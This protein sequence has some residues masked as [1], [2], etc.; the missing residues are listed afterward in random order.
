MFEYRQTWDLYSN[1]K[2]KLRAFTPKLPWSC[3]PVIGVTLHCWTYIEPASGF[4]EPVTSVVIY[5]SKEDMEDTPVMDLTAQISQES[6]EKDG[7]PYRRIVISDLDLPCFEDGPTCKMLFTFEHACVV[8]RTEIVWTID[9]GGSR[10]PLPDTLPI[11]WPSKNSPVWLVG[12]KEFV[13]KVSRTISD[14]WGGLPSASGFIPPGIHLM[15]VDQIL[16]QSVESN[17]YSSRDHFDG[18]YRIVQA[19][20]LIDDTLC[21]HTAERTAEQILVFRYG[22][23]C[24]LDA[25]ALSDH[26]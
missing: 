15:V 20:A 5:E 7:G 25:M 14:M 2:E 17:Y 1:P 10:V 12:D 8:T 11:S 23:W 13:L 22:T 6:F 4:I 9:L 21:G 19:S 24:F 3:G 16:R 18:E 26:V